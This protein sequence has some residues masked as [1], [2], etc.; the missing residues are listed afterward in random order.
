VRQSPAWTT[1]TGWRCASLGR[2]PRAL[3]NRDRPIT[4]G[5]SRDLTTRT[6]VRR[7]VGCH[8][9]S[10]LRLAAK[11]P[12]GEPRERKDCERT[13]ASPVEFTLYSPH[14]ELLE[15]GTYYFCRGH[16]KELYALESTPTLPPAEWFEGVDL[17]AEPPR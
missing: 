7:L 8:Q 9:A 15:A 2:G 6:I 3:K 4:D 11:P 16:S 13:D 1:W 5:R 10:R 17:E 12:P 14:G